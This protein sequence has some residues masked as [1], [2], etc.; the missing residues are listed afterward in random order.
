VEISTF[1]SGAATLV[2]EVHNG[3]VWGPNDASSQ[4]GLAEHDKP[5]WLISKHRI[6]SISVGSFAGSG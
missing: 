1:W 3:A 6:H 2:P 5:S 4:R